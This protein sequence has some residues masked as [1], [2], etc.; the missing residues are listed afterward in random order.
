MRT[1]T[2]RS[3]GTDQV[4]VWRREQLVQSGLPPS[5]AASLAKDTRYDLHAL[6]G[7][8]EHGCP[9]R[10]AIRILAPLDGGDAA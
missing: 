5:L 7:L 10:L 1:Q 9:P 3:P 8:V 6:I 2:T 4:E